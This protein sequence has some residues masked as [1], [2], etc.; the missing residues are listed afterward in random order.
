MTARKKDGVWLVRETMAVDR[1][2]FD[3]TANDLKAYI[4]SVVDRALVMGM[5]GEGRFDFDTEDE[6]FYS[7]SFTI[8]VT[9][10]FERVENEKEQARREAAEAKLKEEKAAKRR[11]A[12]DARKLKQDAEYAEYLRLKEKFKEV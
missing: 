2:G 9:Y 11:A 8:K 6:G 1:W 3:G 7:P 5:V 10:C 4:D 12:A